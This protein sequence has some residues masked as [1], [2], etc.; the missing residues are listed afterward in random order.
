MWLVFFSLYLLLHPV[1]SS[2]LICISFPR[3]LVNVRHLGADP[4]KVALVFALYVALAV[5]SKFKR[6]CLGSVIEAVVKDSPVAITLSL[7][8]DPGGR[9]AL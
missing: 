3:Y 9:S 5:S 8:L 6:S 7:P 4:A 2:P 1:G